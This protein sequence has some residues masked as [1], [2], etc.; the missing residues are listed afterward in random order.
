MWVKFKTISS[1]VASKHERRLKLER[2]MTETETER[3]KATK[4]QPK[5]VLNWKSKSLLKFLSELFYCNYHGII[6]LF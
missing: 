6:V 5:N 4:K 2:E 1:K 3:Q